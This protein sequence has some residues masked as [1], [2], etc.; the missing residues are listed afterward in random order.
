MEAVSDMRVP[1]AK[2]EQLLPGIIRLKPLSV[3]ERVWT[4]EIDKGLFAGINENSY[5]FEGNVGGVA[6]FIPAGAVIISRDNFQ[7]CV[8]VFDETGAEIIFDDDRRATEFLDLLNRLVW[9]KVLET[10]SKA[11]S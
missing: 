10:E 4:V 3:R 2:L 6:L 8:A 11:S 7:S 1:P 5:P 9:K